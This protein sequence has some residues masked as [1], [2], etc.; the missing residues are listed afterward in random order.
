M[1]VCSCQYDFWVTVENLF[2]DGK[3]NLSCLVMKLG[4]IWNIIDINMQILVFIL[5][6][7]FWE[8]DKRAICET[9]CQNIAGEFDAFLKLVQV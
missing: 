8:L 7:T 2:H 3:K 9:T 5:D 6:Y 4:E 1:C